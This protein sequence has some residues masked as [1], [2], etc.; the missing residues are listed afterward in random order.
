M[1]PLVRRIAAGSLSLLTS[2]C[3]PTDVVVA[4]VPPAPDAGAPPF[5]RMP[6]RDDTECPSDSFCEA[7]ACDAALGECRRRPVFCPPDVRPVCGC[8]GVT[9]FNDCLRS[10]AG[11]RASTD[12]A[13]DHGPSCGGPNDAA[14][15]D[16]EAK[17]ARLVGRPDACGDREP[18]ACWVVPT[19]CPSGWQ[20]GGAWAS[21]SDPNGS[22]VDAC[23]AITSETPHRPRPNDTCF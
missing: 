6:C 14:C 10:R 11:I 20:E 13:C 18:G 5:S 2:A 1:S 15:P 9:Y 21:C 8:N 22:C 3:S 12:G 17:C 7:A 4:D 16:P 19:T 23:E